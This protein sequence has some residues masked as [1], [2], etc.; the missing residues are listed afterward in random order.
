MWGAVR[1]SGGPQPGGGRYLAIGSEGGPRICLELG[2]S[3]VELPR[4]SL[5][6]QE[7]GALG[8]AEEAGGES[9]RAEGGALLRRIAVAAQL[10]SVAGISVWWALLRPKVC[11][12]TVGF[13]SRR[14]ADSLSEDFARWR[15]ERIRARRLGAQAP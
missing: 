1:D 14:L 3:E 2:G 8:V 6:V 10:P 5:D 7:I 11:R 12:Q 13:A 15:G 4:F 9:C